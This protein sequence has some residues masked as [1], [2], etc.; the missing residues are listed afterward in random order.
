MTVTLERPAADVD[1]ID[2]RIGSTTD[3]SDPIAINPPIPTLTD[4][5]TCWTCTLGNCGPFGTLAT[6]FSCLC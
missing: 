6:I 1:D 4:S 5:C 3:L 2:L